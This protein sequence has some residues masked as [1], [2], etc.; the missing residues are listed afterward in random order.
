MLAAAAP[1]LYESGDAWS[2]AWESAPR[3]VAY[4]TGKIIALKAQYNAYDNRPIGSLMADCSQEH[5]SFRAC[6][7]ASGVLAVN[8]RV[9]FRLAKPGRATDVFAEP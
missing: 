3:K 8:V 2:R 5:F 4:R 9:G 6:D 7:V 1:P